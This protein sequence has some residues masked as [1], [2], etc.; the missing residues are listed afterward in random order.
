MLQQ[1]WHE[2]SPA[3]AQIMDRD[4]TSNL[5]VAVVLLLVGLL[6]LIAYRTEDR[7]I[8]RALLGVVGVLFCVGGIWVLLATFGAV[9][10]I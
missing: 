2:P 9:P 10:P 1:P 5:I 3:L 7:L 4:S 8:S 6:L